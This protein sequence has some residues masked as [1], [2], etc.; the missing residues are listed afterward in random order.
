[1][2]RLVPPSGQT[3]AAR[4][5]VD[6]AA[7]Q[8]PELRGHSCRRAHT[9]KV[10]FWQCVSVIQVW[11]HE[12]EWRFKPIEWGKKTVMFEFFWFLFLSGPLSSVMRKAL[13]RICS[14]LL[15]KQEEL[16]SLDRA[17]GDGDCGNTHAQAARGTYLSIC[18]RQDE[19]SSQCCF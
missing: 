6:A 18:K 17:T 10:R 9:L 15:E 8:T 16:N 3:S 7:S 2:L 12:D 5:S 19:V 11:Q 14:T 4:V 1:M 13:Q